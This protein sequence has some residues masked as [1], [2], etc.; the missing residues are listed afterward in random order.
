[1]ELTWGQWRSMRQKPEVI[2]DDTGF[3][4]DYTLIPY[5]TY[6]TREE[7]QIIPSLSRTAGSPLKNGYLE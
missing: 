1:M 5:P 2:S 6:P 3:A 7:F 4:R